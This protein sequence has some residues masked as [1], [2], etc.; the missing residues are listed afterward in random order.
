M[1]ARHVGTASIWAER[2]VPV[3]PGWMDAEITVGWVT[4]G[5]M[6]GGRVEERR[7]RPGCCAEAKL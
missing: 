4:R 6:R 2:R 1:T 7:G 3:I 5:M